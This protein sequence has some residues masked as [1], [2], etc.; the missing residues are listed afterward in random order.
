MKQAGSIGTV[1]MAHVL[2]DPDAPFFIQGD[3]QISRG[4][5]LRQVVGVRAFFSAQGIAAGAVVGL[6]NT[7]QI[8][9]FAAMFALW[10]LGAAPLVLD[11]RISQAERQHVAQAAGVSAIFSDFKGLSAQSGCHSLPRDLPLSDDIMALTFPSDPDAIV[12]FRQSSGTTALPKLQPISAQTLFDMTEKRCDPPSHVTQGNIVSCLNLAFAGTRYLWFRNAYLGRAIISVPLFFTPAQL[13]TAMRHPLAE[14]ATLPPVIMK[15]LVEY[16]DALDGQPAHPRYPNLSK[17]QSIGGPLTGQMLLDVQRLLSD[18]ISTT[19][20]FS[21]AGVVSRLYGDDIARNPTAAGRVLSGV[22]VATEDQDGEPLPAHMPGSLV[23]TKDGETF[24]PGDH[25]YLSDEGLLYITGRSA[26]RFCRNSVTFTA[27]DVA[28][29]I[30]SLDTVTD[31][32]VFAAPGQLDGEDIVVA[33]IESDPANQVDIAST[34]RSL[35]LAEIRPD[36]I[37]CYPALPRGSAMKVSIQDLKQHHLQEPE[38]YHD[39]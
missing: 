13:D 23:V 4:D 28:E 35:M 3:T 20:S 6:A 2:A 27:S 31:C 37:R 1:F 39:L 17:L 32:C 30:R 38:K 29:R 16:V 19:Y 34:L 15:R 10:S 18:R 8:R 33:A 12:D 5:F 24:R 36:H 22:T 9:S 21:E 11:Y 26:E 14:E 7:D 25:G